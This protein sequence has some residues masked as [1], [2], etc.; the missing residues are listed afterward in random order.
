MLRTARWAG[1]LVRW[2]VHLMLP[3][4]AG[5]ALVSLG[6]GMVVG[7]VFGHALALWAILALSGGFLLWIGASVNQAPRPPRRSQQPGE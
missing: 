6:G 4:L 5:A 3:G 1:T 7:H 2:R